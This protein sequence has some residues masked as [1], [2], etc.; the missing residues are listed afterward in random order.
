MSAE[1]TS[2]GRR[3]W[4]ILA[5]GVAAQAATSVFQFGM[6]FLLPQLRDLVGGDLAQAGLLVAC[7]NLGLML[8][9]IAW[10]W[11]ADT[12]G[13]RLAMTIGLA[14]TAV[15]L[16]AAALVQGPVAL[17]LLLVLAGAAAA[18]VNAS[19]G[20]VV[21]A[22]FGPRERGLA[23]GIRHS[24]QP[25]GVAIAGFTMPPI[26]AAGEFRAALFLPAALCGVIAVAVVVVIRDPAATAASAGVVAGSPYRHAPIWLVHGASAALIVPQF[27]ISSFAY[28]YLVT[29]QHLEPALA[30]SILGAT[31]LVG[32]VGR[33]AAG[34]W[35]DVVGD[36]LGPMRI[37]AGVNAG[38]LAV[39]AVVVALGWW[40]AVPVF[41]IAA[42]ITVSGNGL[43]FTAVAE[44]AGRAWSGRA[45]GTQNT[46]Q[47]AVAFATPAAIG[48]VVTAGGFGVGF[49]AA[50]LFP[51]LATV[52][53]PRRSA[54]RP[55]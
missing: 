26:A 4:A 18:S 30:G 55:A 28:L 42:I 50:I 16:V 54:P 25:L 14:V 9:L 37:L 1:A 48:T 45:L 13:E 35:S 6:P 51:L 39:L 46:V 41:L 52:I 19:S 49:A 8:T 34:R 31:Q 29:E 23:M 21:M 40:I 43:A 11:V 36:R 7:P 22:W 27:A 38:V 5:V 32:A 17:G 2:A 24:A 20:R 53:I 12:V 3:R 15:V 44:I 47:N 33:L 10:G